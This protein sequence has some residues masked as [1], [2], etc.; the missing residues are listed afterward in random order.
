MSYEKGIKFNVL[1]DNNPEYI[2][3]A[4]FL[5]IIFF[6]KSKKDSIFHGDFHLGNFLFRI[7]NNKLKM[8]VLDFGVII[9]LNK[10]EK[11]ILSNF[12]LDLN[13]DK[14]KI[15]NDFLVFNSKFN[16]LRNIDKEK[17]FKMDLNILNENIF[18]KVPIKYLGLL[19]SAGILKEV[20]LY[21]K[22]NNIKII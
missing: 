5:I 10:Y 13:I 11:D 2:E 16:Y 22:K 6:Y 21:L 8:I 17:I 20:F 4:L 19:S 15:Y 14:E 7:D 18:I 1:K 12:K 9:K 3:Q